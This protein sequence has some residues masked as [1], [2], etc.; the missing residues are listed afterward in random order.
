M[1]YHLNKDAKVDFICVRVVAVTLF[2]IWCLFITHIFYG[3]LVPKV[4]GVTITRQDLHRPVAKMGPVTLEITGGNIQPDK[5]QVSQLQSQIDSTQSELDNANSFPFIVKWLLKY[6][7]SVVLK[8]SQVEGSE[9][10][11]NSY[12]S[13]NGVSAT[14]NVVHS[15]KN[16]SL[17]DFQL[18]M[19]NSLPEILNSC[20]ETVQ[21][22]DN[23]PL[24]DKNYTVDET[25]GFTINTTPNNYI[26]LFLIVFLGSCAIL[27][28]IREGIKFFKSG[29]SY[30]GE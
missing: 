25:Y 3:E 13:C 21:N 26:I 8:N 12:L 15:L 4:E 28:V 9:K 11:V 1:N 6:D 17:E 23:S 5:T 16:V 24:P 27:P 18:E 10:K 29:F 30:F 22:I 14:N 19:K 20:S 2:L 7:I